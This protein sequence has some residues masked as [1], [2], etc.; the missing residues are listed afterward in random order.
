MDTPRSAGLSKGVRSLSMHRGAEPVKNGQRFGSPGAPT[1]SSKSRFLK[2]APSAANVAD[3]IRLPSRPPTPRAAVLAPQPKPAAAPK[4]ALLPPKK[5]QRLVPPPEKLE[6]FKAAFT[7]PTRVHETL[8]SP[9][10]ELIPPKPVLETVLPHWLKKAMTLKAPPTSATESKIT[11][12]NTDRERLFG[13]FSF[14]PTPVPGDL[15]RIFVDPAWVRKNILEVNVPQLK[16][17][18]NIPFRGVA[19]HKLVMPH[20]EE[21]VAAWEKEGLIP[22][23]LTWNG[24]YVPRFRRGQADKQVLSN[25]AYGSAFDINARWNPFRKP[26]APPK[27]EGSVRELAVVAKRLGWIWGGDFHS[28]DGMHFEAG[29]RLLGEKELSMSDP[30][31]KKVEETEDSAEAKNAAEEADI[32]AKLDALVMKEPETPP[33][34]A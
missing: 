29:P 2:Q 20:F 8:P 4:R 3:V 5:K 30:T 6:R 34:V 26:S 24:G 19:L 23:I 16:K 12:T 25:H 9:P 21:L 28:P 15:E 18:Q 10:A 17:V 27:A 31:E 33:E 11:L 1:R 32:Q 7:P 22:K 13:K 14:K